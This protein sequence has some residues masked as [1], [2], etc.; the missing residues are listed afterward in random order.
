MNYNREIK[1]LNVKGNMRHCAKNEALSQSQHRALALLATYRHKMHVNKREFY[2][3]ESEKNRRYMDF[4]T[5]TMPIMLYQ[6]AL[7]ELNLEEELRVLVTDK[8]VYKYEATRLPSGRYFEIVADFIAESINGKIEEYLGR[9][10]CEYGT[11]YAP[12]RYARYSRPA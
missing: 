12:T 11:S 3:S 1:E 4:L 6:A 10:D 5:K 9:I 8:D 7:P 2:N